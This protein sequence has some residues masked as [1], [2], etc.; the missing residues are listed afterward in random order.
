MSDNNRPISFYLMKILQI[1][2]FNYRKGGSEVVYFSTM[3]LL[4]M[5]GEE[6]VN[7]ALR[8]PENYPSEYESYFP[9]SKE[10]RSELLKP[11]KNIINYFNNREAARK[12]EQLIEKER[13]DLAHMHLIW[14]QITGSILPVLKRHNVPIIFSIHDYRIVCPAYTFRN[15]KGEICEQCRGRNFYHCVINKCTKDSYLLSVMMAIEQCYRN[16]F[17]NPAEYIDGLIYVSQFAKQMHEKYMPELKEK[18]NIVLYNLAD[19][20]L[21][22][23]AQKT[24]RY[25]LFFGRL[26]YEKGV[27]TL[28]S[29]FKDMP[30]CNLKIAGTGPLEDELKD[31]TKSNNVTNVEFLGYKSGKELTDLVENAYFIIVPSEWYENNPMTIIEGYAAGVPVI[32]TNI[33]GIPEIIEE[34]VTGYLFTPANS[35]DLTRVVKAADSLPVEQYSNY[36]QNALSFARKHFDREKYY[37]QLIG[38]YNQLVKEY[39]FFNP[40]L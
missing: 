14:G 22:A 24:D 25:F 32:G 29:A 13:P 5:H 3:E 19:K 12:L 4:R 10:T 35:V 36:Q 18:R 31:Y 9:E 20:I 6:V 34:G 1:N 23:P 39:I 30:N 21:D 16:R 33:G 37:P 2:V 38:F 26:S 11:V 28:I 15:G 27:K 7:F 8:W 17:F 40:I